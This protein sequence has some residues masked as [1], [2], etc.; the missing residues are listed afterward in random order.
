MPYK[1][2]LVTRSTDTSTVTEDTLNK[3]SALTHGELDSDLINL[4]DQS[5]G[6]AS[7]DS[8]VIDVGM[9]NTLTIAG[10]AGI[11]TTVSGQTVTIA[12]DGTITIV[13]D[14]STGTAITIGETFKIAGASGI[15][16]AVSGD[17]LTITGPS[18]TSYLQNVVE[19]TTPQLG[20]NLDVNSNSIV[21]ASNGTI[22]IQPNGTGY[23]SLG[24]GDLKANLKQTNILTPN[25]VMV[26]HGANRTWVQTTDQSAV[27]A[28]TQRIYANNDL[29]SVQLTGTTGTNSN[30]RI[31]QMSAVEVDLNGINW[32][33]DQSGYKAPIVG[34][35]NFVEIINQSATA[36]TITQAQGANGTAN[37]GSTNA[38]AQAGDITITDIIGMS[39]AVDVLAG[40]GRTTS[41][42]NAY[43][44]YVFLTANGAGTKS[45]T[46]WYGLYAADTSATVTNKYGVYVA[47]PTFNNYIGGLNFANGA[48]STADSTAIQIDEGVNISGTLNAKIIVA[49]E[50]SSED[51]SAIQINDA[52]NVSGATTLHGSTRFN[53]HYTEKINTLASSTAITVDASTA[54]VHKIYLENNTTFKVTNLGTGGSLT[55]IIQQDSTGSR[56]GAF[57]SDDST[58]IR[59]AG[60]TPTLSTTGNS[61][62]IV[63]IFNDGTFYFGNIAKAF[64]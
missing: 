30:N 12:A 41:V 48:I 8:T 33:Y 55:L 6:I 11:S 23:V 62:D 64:A 18:L 50:I 37:V 38:T 49:N 56:L 29:L 4:R 15:T 24:Y 34:R 36:A 10:G 13:G 26:D 14:D 45:I 58:A 27:S 40:T 61:I 21:S 54:P 28:N 44:Q 63:N 7:D 51:S 25:N 17:T 47:N 9:G 19:D 60:G 35:H 32:G 59:F 2:K 1:A 43:G 20:G 22:T 57:V 5:I 42:T 46:N 3:G 52:L 39:G 31:R 53:N 16:T